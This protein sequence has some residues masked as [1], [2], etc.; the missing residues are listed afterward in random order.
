MRIEKQGKNELRKKRPLVYTREL[1]TYHTLENNVVSEALF[2]ISNI[3][4]SFDQKLLFKKLQTFGFDEKKF[5]YF[6]MFSLH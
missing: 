5:F 1:V 2:K 3:F 6:W 4:Y